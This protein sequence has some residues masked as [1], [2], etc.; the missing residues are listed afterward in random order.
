MTLLVRDFLLGGGTFDEL[1][2][3]HGVIAKPHNGK[4]SFVYDQIGA[5]RGNPL[6]CQCRGLILREGTWDVVAYP[7]NRF[8][9]H[10]EAP[11]AS[12]I[13]WGTAAFEEKLDGTLIIAYFDTVLLRWMCAT[14]SMCEAH[15]DI[16]GR[17]TFAKLADEAARDALDAESFHH[18]MVERGANTGVTYMFELTGPDNRIVV[19]YREL[20]LTLLGA[21]RLHDFAELD[22]THPQINPGFRTPKLWRFSNIAELH[23]VAKT[24]DAFQYEGV[25]VKDAHFRRVKVKAPQYLAVAHLTDS[26]GASW[27]SCLELVRTGGDRDVIGKAPPRIA[28]RIAAMR[29]ALE[30]VVGRA[31]EEL[32]KLNGVDDMKTF[33]LAATK[34]A[35]S[36]PL[37]AVKRR[38]AESVLAFAAQCPLDNLVELC[39]PHIPEALR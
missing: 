12:E 30:T 39:L 33:A 10:D 36:A 9:N 27:R 6:A 19:E 35:W 26:I 23:E 5:D 17:G 4:V 34:T 11:F 16:N 18:A 29:T 8:F 28:E 1:R 2:A 7:F 22:V 37:F 13:D 21:R 14:R 32:A 3:Q 31:E 15:G 25:I 20:G 24:W 38:K